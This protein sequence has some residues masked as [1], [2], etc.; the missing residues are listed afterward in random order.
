MIKLIFFLFN[1]KALSIRVLEFLIIF[2]SDHIVDRLDFYTIRG[3][4]CGHANF[5]FFK[6]NLF[7]V[8]C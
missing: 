1:Y 7:R 3:V 6:T 4:F 8:N 5:L 2:Y